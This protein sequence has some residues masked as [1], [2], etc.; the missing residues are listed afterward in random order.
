VRVSSYIGTLFLLVTAGC[1]T[2]VR[3]SVG[4]SYSALQATHGT[5]V[6]LVPGAM[7]SL[8]ALGEH[9]SSCAEL[10]GPDLQFVEVSES[11]SLVACVDPDGNVVC[12]DTVEGVAQALE[13]LGD[14]V[15]A[16]FDGVA[17]EFEGSFYEDGSATEATEKRD[18]EEQTSSLDEGDDAAVSGDPSPQPSA[19]A[20]G[21]PS[22]QPSSVESGDPSPQPSS[23]SSGD[24]SPQPSNDANGADPSPQPSN[25]AN[26]GDPS[27]QPSN[28]A[29]D[30]PSPQPS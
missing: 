27:P 25:D 18:E 2:D 9:E 17:D 8:E 26:G 10:M 14:A 6:E 22:P 4:G 19:V 20:G 15:L 16:Q 12:V 24:P 29:S 28:V 30:D 5:S 3:E 13:E 23:A 7:V 1:A 11:D 21:D